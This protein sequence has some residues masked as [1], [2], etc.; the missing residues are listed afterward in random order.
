MSE[1]VSAF[2]Q[3]LIA[4]AYTFGGSADL[5]ASPA[6]SGGKV[7]APVQVGTAIP[8]IIVPTDDAA[9]Y[10][11]PPLG[12]AGGRV[13]YIGI[14]RD[15]APSIIGGHELRQGTVTYKVES[16]GNWTLGRVIGLSLPK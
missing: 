12:L 3:G 14:L 6:A 9:K 13:S 1:Y 15:D 7:G 5:Y 8:I 11:L 10:G 4:L 2:R 16:A